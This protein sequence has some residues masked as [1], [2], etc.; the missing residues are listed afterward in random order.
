MSHEFLV[1]FLYPQAD[2]ALQT[3]TRLWQ[4]AVQHEYPRSHVLLVAEI[5]KSTTVH[6]FEKGS[7][8]RREQSI[9]I[10]GT[11]LTTAALEVRD[12]EEAVTRTV[13]EINAGTPHAAYA[14]MILFSS[15][16]KER[17]RP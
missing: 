17:I 13:Q 9:T 8:D 2:D 1:N 4:Q 15:L 14:P 5:Y 7:K 10:H 11:E 16:P 12:F 6:V 3:I